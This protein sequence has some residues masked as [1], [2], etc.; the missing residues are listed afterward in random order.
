MDSL[1][2]GQLVTVASDGPTRNGIVFDTPSRGKVVVAVVDA[3]RGPVFVTV[4]P[5]VLAERTEEGPE[6]RALQMLIRRTPQPVRGAARGASAGGRGSRGHTR[7]AAHRA[8]G[9]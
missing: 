9:R 8:T 4:H 1:G 6:D 2:T 5:D 7:G 3:G